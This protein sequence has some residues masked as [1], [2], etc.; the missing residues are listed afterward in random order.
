MEY[1]IYRKHVLQEQQ[2]IQNTMKPY[3]QTA[4]RKHYPS[5]ALYSAKPSFSDQDK[6]NTF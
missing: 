4:E 1:Q 3:P 2:R 5:Q 6:I